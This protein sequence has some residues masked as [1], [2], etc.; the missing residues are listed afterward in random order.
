M[1]PKIHSYLQDMLIHFV[2][3]T[4]SRYVRY[5][6]LLVELNLI[7]LLKPSTSIVLPK[8]NIFKNQHVEKEVR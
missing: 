5:Y 6:Y 4:P 8:R 2:P 3:S 1:F 7:N